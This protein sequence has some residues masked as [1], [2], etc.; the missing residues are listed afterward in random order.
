MGT[1]IALTYLTFSDC[2]QELLQ[3]NEVNSDNYFHRIV[4]DDEIR[5]VYYYDPLSQQ[6]AK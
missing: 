3:E 1:K 4:T 6:E 2:C 5:V